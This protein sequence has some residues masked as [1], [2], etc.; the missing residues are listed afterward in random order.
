MQKNSITNKMTPCCGLPFSVVYWW[1]SNLTLNSESDRQFILSKISQNGT[2]SIDGWKVLV[3]SGTLEADASL[4]K[5]EFLAWFDCG[6]Q[7]TCE[8]LKLI[9]E[10]F[11]ISNWSAFYNSVDE[12]NLAF[13][14]LENKLK[15]KYNNITE[16]DAIDII[17]R[18]DQFTGENV[19][20]KEVTTWYDGTPMTDAKLDNVIF[21]KKGAKYYKKQISKQTLLKINTI[22]DL[23]NFNGYYEG[24]E[25]VLMGYYEAGDKEPL[26]YKWTL[27][28][29]V[30]N[31]GSVIN[32]SKGSWK[33]ILGDIV[34]VKHFGAKGDGITDDTSSIISALNYF[35][36]NTTIVF[37]K[38]NYLITKLI[39]ENKVDFNLFGDIGA[40]LT[41]KSINDGNEKGIELRGNLDNVSIKSLEILGDGILTS[42]HQAIYSNSGQTLKNINISDNKISNCIVGISANAN[43]SGLIKNYVIKNN[44]I[45][46]IVGTESGSGYGVHYA[47]NDII[48]PS[49][50][51]VYGNVIDNCQRHAIYIG[52]GNGVIV[53]RNIIT[54]HR[55]KVG[56][57]NIRCAIEV[58]R[59]NNVKILY[60]SVTSTK[61]SCLSLLPDDSTTNGTTENL[62]AIGNFLE[63]IDVTPCVIINY[64]S[65][66][67]RK[68]LKNVIVSDNIMKSASNSCIFYYAGLNVDIINNSLETTGNTISFY[69]TNDG[70]NTAKL[71]SDNVNIK[72]NKLKGLNAFRFNSI[73]LSLCNIKFENNK[74]DITN[75]VFSMGTYATN[76]N[77][78]LLD[79]DMNF[80]GMAFSGSI[81]FKNT[82][83]ATPNSF[84]K[85]KKSTLQT[86]ST[87]TTIA[88]LVDDFNELL[89]KLKSAG[90]MES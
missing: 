63:T 28:Q 77:I 15:L 73:H 41:L 36:S 34:D 47:S 5:T 44:T 55:S 49:N 7:P 69:A 11:K 48:N 84:G 67:S 68:K 76:P 2:I 57:G 40:K 10:G 37:P 33:A 64:I 82:N 4:T 85:V 66:E 19:N 9:I 25:V 16:S 27:T 50:V 14:E 18:V 61:G 70:A 74:Y 53:E 32:S 62:T 75:E 71:F 88:G 21:I 22:A 52:R 56:D 24:Q 12:L 35:N 90:L 6:K 80:S 79:D 8:Q 26:T 54:N 83:L 87:A 51:L 65:E 17:Q 13:E 60:N 89:S 58:S 46:N 86:N 31:G 42:K 38:G 43:L 72:N 29:G 59:T 39:V 78:S 1:I 45:S 20:Y 23:R 3:N 30:D 81:W